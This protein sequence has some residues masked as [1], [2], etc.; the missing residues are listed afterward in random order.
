MKKMKCGFLFVLIAI[1]TIGCGSKQTSKNSPTVMSN[2]A[3]IESVDMGYDEGMLDVTETSISDSEKKT[4]VNQQKLIKTSTIRME[5]KNFDQMIQTITQKVETLDGYIES[6]DVSGYG[7]NTYEGY[8]RYASFTVR[9]P[10]ENSN[11]FVDDLGNYG[12]I[13]SK[14]E[15]IED[16]TLSY[17]DTESRI[18]AL[19]TE[20]NRLIELMAS[21]ENVDSVIALESRISE[22]NYQKETYQSQLRVLDNQIEYCKIYINLNEVE[23]ETPVEKVGFWG[24]IAD[25]FTSNIRTI[26]HGIRSFLIVVISSIPYLAVYIGIIA[27]FI[28][29]IKLLDYKIKK[30]KENMEQLEKEGEL[31]EKFDQIQKRVS[32]KIEKE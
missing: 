26:F 13:T 29:I 14:N 1:F 30:K 21:A 28:W 24:E 7:Y 8:T 16:V 18:K 20:Y 10:E 25:R 32:E 23:S 19:E 12:T 4:N 9:I 27:F 22:I 2:M 5:T 11:L 17:V 15:T 31:K 6:S 3:S